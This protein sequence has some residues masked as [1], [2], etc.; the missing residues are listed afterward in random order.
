[1][2]N[3]RYDT[4]G[5]WFKGNTHI[6]SLA[7]D[8]GK[9]F[10]ELADMYSGVG[11][12]F[13]F[14]TDHWVASDVDND[15]AKYPLLWCDGTELD[16]VDSTGAGYHVVCLGKNP[17]LNREIGLNA[18]MKEAKKN[19]CVLILAHP[20]WC[21]NSFEDALRWPFH[22]VEI[23]NHVCRWLNGKGDG[24][25]YWE[26]MLLE[27]P[28]V[29]AFASDDTHLRGEH[30]T[31]NGGWIVI[32]AKGLTQESVMAAIK[33]GNFYSSQG[34]EFKEIEFDGKTVKTRTS[35]VKF[36][37]LVGEA[38]M[39]NRIG[40]LDNASISEFE[41]EIPENMP[42][43]FLEIEDENGKRAWT[44]NLFRN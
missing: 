6:H 23:Y 14:R 5:E 30:I 25:S 33:A 38:S 1:M 24:R 22:G 18:G 35:K 15:T 10:A 3:F 34:P 19:G 42:F 44:N 29:L 27:N 26:K 21:G 41:F 12:D 16:G 13:L 39:G 7:S 20:A 32:N 4:N 11:Y 40:D 37:R 17:E 8:G 28:D 9:S 31:W 43:A 2:K 36:A